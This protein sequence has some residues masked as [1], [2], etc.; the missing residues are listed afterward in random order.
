[1]RAPAVIAILVVVSCVTPA[2]AGAV[3]LSQFRAAN[4]AI[5]SSSDDQALARLANPE[6]R[7]LVE[8]AFDTRVLNEV[9]WGNGDLAITVCGEA[10]ATIKRYVAPRA[11]LAS[12]D[13]NPASAASQKVLR[14]YGARYHDEQALGARFGVECAAR[15]LD[16][17][18]APDWS[19]VPA[20]QRTNQ[21]RATVAQIQRS[22]SDV[23]S[24]ALITL[25]EP[26]FTDSNKL[27]ILD[28][29]ERNA[30]K[31]GRAAGPFERQQIAQRI[32]SV[33][34]GLPPSIRMRVKRISD[35]IS[36]TPCTALCS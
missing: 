16:E 28:A 32:A 6:T 4:L 11:L 18:L 21:R 14:A 25:A 2:Q 7:Q 1:M 5:Q 20:E 31:F 3:S 19:S 27:L 26:I 36:S 9:D 17:F 12:K 8:T 35:T 10:T 34:S 15:F 22:L 23:F 30:P 13:F 33:Q 29:L 24:G